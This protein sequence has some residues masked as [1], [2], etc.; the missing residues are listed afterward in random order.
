MYSA[1]AGSSPRLTRPSGTTWSEHS[2]NSGGPIMQLLDAAFAGSNRSAASGRLGS[3]GDGHRYRRKTRRSDG[4]L[5][6]AHA[7][8]VAVTRG[9]IGPHARP[10]LYYSCTRVVADRQGRGR[11]RL[12]LQLPSQVDSRRSRGRRRCDVWSGDWQ[13]GLL[14]RLTAPE[15]SWST[16]PRPSQA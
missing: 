12:R 1:R 4:Q 11:P 16:S 6:T 2:N 9:A 10:L 7:E 14:R 8:Q 15:R 5:R 13:P 3:L